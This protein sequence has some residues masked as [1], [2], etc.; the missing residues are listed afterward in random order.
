MKFLVMTAFVWSLI[1]TADAAGLQRSYSQGAFDQRGGAPDLRRTQSDR[2]AAMSADARVMNFVKLLRMK[3]ASGELMNKKQL[4]FLEKYKDLQLSPADEQA[5]NTKRDKTL[6]AIRQKKA[7]PRGMMGMLGM[8]GLSQAEQ[9]FLTRNQNRT[10]TADASGMEIRDVQ[11]PAQ[12]TEKG[13]SAVQILGMRLS[14]SPFANL[15]TP[16][17]GVGQAQTSLKVT[18]LHQSPFLVIAKGGGKQYQMPAALG[19]RI[20]HQVSATSRRDAYRKGLDEQGRAAMDAIRSE[21]A[22]QRLAP[23]EDVD[24]RGSFMD[25]NMD[26]DLADAF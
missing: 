26:G 11:V 21:R 1:G 17:S 22:A 15:V 19:A 8:G 14:T 20:D 13:G 16:G 18:E 3:E 12:K 2:T 23:E 4:A 9:A 24:L 10:I 6:A 25:Q 7:K 5:I